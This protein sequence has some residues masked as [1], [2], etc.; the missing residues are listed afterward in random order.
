[1]TRKS[2]N[3]C[4]ERIFNE[5]FI[6]LAPDLHS[7]LL[8]KF[9]RVDHIEDIMQ[10]AFTILWRNCIKV[11]PDFARSYLYKVSQNQFLKLLDKEKVRR[12]YLNLQTNWSDIED[13]EFTIRHKELSEQ[14]KRTLEALPEELREV[15]LLNRIDGKKYREIAEMLDISV[16]T[17]EKRMQRALLQLRQVISNI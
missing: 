1:M 13:P 14:L 15:F 3:V 5:L 2:E 6:R 12:M 9:G 16:K 4:E 8:Y 17:V 10:E 11:A 7:F